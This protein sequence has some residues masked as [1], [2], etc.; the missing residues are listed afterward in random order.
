MEC[1]VWLKRNS[2]WCKNSCISVYFRTPAREHCKTFLCWLLGLNISSLYYFSQFVSGSVWKKG[3]F[4]EIVF[5]CECY[6]SHFLKVSVLRNF[7][8][9]SYLFKRIYRADSDFFSLFQTRRGWCAKDLKNNSIKMENHASF[10][11]LEDVFGRFNRRREHRVN[12]HRNRLPSSMRNKFKN[13][14]CSVSFFF[15][16]LPFTHQSLFFLSN[17]GNMRYIL[18]IWVKYHK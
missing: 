9:T 2:V 10:I 11:T 6:F 16:P 8:L 1:C 4:V 18:S 7:R 14:T 5:F 17:F 3:N 15:F 12:G 13:R